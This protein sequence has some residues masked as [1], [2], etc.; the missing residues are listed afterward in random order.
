[1]LFFGRRFPASPGA[2]AI[3]CALLLLPLAGCGAHESAVSGKVTIEGTPLTSGTV[4]FYP[5][6]GGAAAYGSI[7]SDGAYTIDTGDSGG[8]AAGEYVV[9]VVATTPPQPGFSFGKLLTPTRYNN[10]QTSDLKFT[11]T[12]GRNTIDL[13]LKS[14]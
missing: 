9:T 11:V 8:L 4:V 2:C 5:A 14:K 13:P 12:P 6:G 1:M 7:Q 3:Y 10:K